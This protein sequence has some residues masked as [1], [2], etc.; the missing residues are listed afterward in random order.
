MPNERLG[1]RGVYAIA[2]LIWS[3]L[4]VAQPS[5]SSERSPVPMTSPPSRLARFMSTNVRTRAC[6]FS[7]VTSC[8]ASSWPMSA[9]VAAHGLSD[10]YMLQRHAQR[11]AKALGIGA[12][13]LL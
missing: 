12:R 5:A 7:Y 4:W 1:D 9:K 13:A 10:V 3:P 11:L 8:R 2:I 6:V